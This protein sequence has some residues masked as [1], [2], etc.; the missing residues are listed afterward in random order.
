M[1]RCT[2]V[3]LAAGKGK[4]MNSDTAKQYLELCGKPVLYYS[5]RAFQDSFVDDIVVVASPDDMDR[6]R[7]DIVEKYGFTKVT[8]MVE[9]GAERYDSV[10]C[11]LRAIDD[12]DYVFI[13]DGARPFIDG[14][15]LERAYD[16]VKRTGTAIVSM[17]VK[18]T[19]KTVDDKGITI[20]TPDRAHVWQ[21]QTPQVFAFG[22]IK[23]AYE[24]MNLMKDE[25]AA[26]GTAITDDA[27]VMER[28]GELPV[29]V[30]EGSYRNIKI[31]TPEDML[32]AEAFLRDRGQ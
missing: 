29:Y 25:V 32:I 1:D 20:D 5:L 21:M 22:P 30:S 28:F 8:H 2:A 31:T 11:G 14:E 6:L 23:Q 17:P 10:L 9:G 18:D 3:V 26:E 19:I 27:M 13:H 16:M 12:C 7:Q 15:I 24:K 4:R